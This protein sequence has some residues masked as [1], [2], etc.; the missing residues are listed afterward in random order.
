MASRLRG[1]AQQ[2]DKLSGVGGGTVRRQSLFRAEDARLVCRERE[3]DRV[4]GLFRCERTVAHA[5]RQQPVSEVAATVSN[6]VWPPLIRLEAA[7]ASL[8]PQDLRLR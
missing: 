4:C 7:A 5:N 8:E 3:Q 6:A 2:A 1:K